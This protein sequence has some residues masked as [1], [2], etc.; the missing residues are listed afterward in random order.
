VSFGN[1]VRH[2]WL[3]LALIA[4][5]AGVL[6]FSDWN[7]RQAANGSLKRVA[8]LQHASQAALDEGIEGILDALAEHGFVDGKTIAL[9]RFN[10]ENDLP[11]ANAIARELVN[12]GYDLV[13]T[14]STLSMQTVA[15]ANQSGKVKHVFGIVADPFSAGI[16]VSKEKPLE[17][18]KHLA[19]IG[20]MVPVEKAFALAKQLNPSLKTVGMVWNAAESN[21]RAYTLAA[22]DACKQLGLT[23]LEANAENTS[24]V[25][26]AAGSLVSRGVQALFISGDVTVLVAVDA[27]V[28]AGKKGKIPTFT[29]IPPNATKGALFDLGAN[30]YEVG[31]QEGDLAAK[32]LNGADMSTIPVI[33][34]VPERLS[35][36]TAALSGLREQWKMPADVIAK[37][38]IVVDGQ[39]VHEKG[40]QGHEAAAAQQGRTYKIGILYFA[41]DEGIDLVLKGL[42]ENLTKEGFIEGKNLEVKRAHAQGEIPNIPALL[43][44]FD[45]QHLDL[46]IPMTTPCLTGACSVVKN[47][48]VV[49][50]A[51]YDPIAA[52]AGKSFTDH[53]PGIT[54]I[55]S[56]PPVEDTVDLIRK[57]VPGVKSVGT[58][59]NSSEANSRKVISVGR[60][61]FK[62]H[63]IR[64]EEVT[65]TGSSE[66]LQ[67]A[68]VV[69]HRGIQAM[70]VTGDNTALQGFDAVSKAAQ[71]AKLPLIINDP[72]FTSRGALASV[73]LG[74][75]QTGLA[76]GT[77]VARVLRGEKP[78]KI[79]F[80]EVAVKKL[81]LNRDVAQRLGVTFPADVLKEATQ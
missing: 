73:G 62:N 3:G 57:L 44:N 5:A 36:N 53:L 30:F 1:G 67:A 60:E 77:M 34:L 10:A 54:G 51:V 16:G 20:S 59:Y 23:L 69:T 66:L 9:Q 32:V 79:P 27:V 21:S 78:D 28:Q 45:N 74:W 15:N 70:W 42:F 2:L 33:N 56:F 75:Y 17:H 35:V 41:P 43:Q 58:V 64:L 47:T 49:F 46:I 8:I 37:A 50:A 18:P 22:R 65:V 71:D 31:R 24:S 12:G 4:A 38:E 72:E 6:L 7:Q 61:A 11:T 63:G 81:V 48:P 25:G 29:I 76:A 52:G 13:I 26:E 40:K 14:A 68:Q 55:G 80:Q 39:G 19:G